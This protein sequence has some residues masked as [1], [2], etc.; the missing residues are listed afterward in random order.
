MGCFALSFGQV[1]GEGFGGY[2]ASCTPRLIDPTAFSGGLIGFT[3]PSHLVILECFPVLAVARESGD[4]LACFLFS[5]YILPCHEGP[6]V[7]WLMNER[8][9]ELV[10]ADVLPRAERE[11]VRRHV[12]CVE[13]YPG[14]WRTMPERFA[15]EFEK[16][17]EETMVK[18]LN[19]GD[20]DCDWRGA[21]FRN[22]DLR[23]DNFIGRELAREVQKVLLQ[24]GFFDAELWF[25]TWDDMEGMQALRERNQ[26]LSETV[27]MRE[28]DL[29]KMKVEYER[30]HRKNMELMELLKQ[31]PMKQVLEKKERIDEL[32]AELMELREELKR[33]KGHLAAV[34]MSIGARGLAQACKVL[35][36][37]VER[38]GVTP[39]FVA[40]ATGLKPDRVYDLLAELVNH[41]LLMKKYH[42]YYEL[43]ADLDVENLEL[44]VALRRVKRWERNSG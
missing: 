5:I 44:E 35:R 31:E 36:V 33:M 23:L 29:S 3:S 43:A 41:G 24:Y 14:F 27:R 19:L 39:S 9:K 8:L 40:K 38:R 26:E 2:M 34:E 1:L 4:C 37:C 30:L 16:K 10:L 7:S 20:E 17:P 13:K 25:V 6:W 28:R 11:L 18:Y 21:D 42:G 12:E 32:M 15:R 22:R